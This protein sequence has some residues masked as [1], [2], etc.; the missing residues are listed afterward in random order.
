MLDQYSDR[1]LLATDFHKNPTESAKADS[2]DRSD[3]RP[4]T[5]DLQDRIG[6]ADTF[7]QSDL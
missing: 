6:V 5:T 7:R 1:R 4:L 3:F 2:F